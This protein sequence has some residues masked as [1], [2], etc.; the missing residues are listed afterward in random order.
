[1]SE[2]DHSLAVIEA[3]DVAASSDPKF[4][5]L[6]VH[7]DYSMCDGL[8]KV[9]P[10]VA[11]A[12]DL[13]MPALAL[14]DQTN[15]CG[16]VKYYH[17]AHG[18]GIKP[19]IGCDFWVKSDE[20]GDELSRLVILTT[21]NVGY[22]NITELISKAY[23][24]GHIQGKA[25]LDKHWLIEHAH[26]LILL[27]GGREGDV[28]KA[29]LKGNV[30]FVE[31]MLSFYQQYFPNCYYLELI[32]T[33]RSD[34]ENYLHLAVDLASRYDLPLVAT[35]EVMFL[36]PEDFDAHEIRVAIHDGFTLDDKRR[37][38]KYSKEQYLRSEEEM[39]ELFADIPEALENS[40]EIAKRC[41][42]TV[43]LGEYVLPDF[44]TEGLSIEDFLVKVSEEGLQE[45]LEF[46]FDKDA[47]DFAEKRK[48]YDERL[49]IE[50]KVIN[51][52]GFPGY[53]L[54]VM[55]FIQ[56]SKDNNIPVG[57]G[58]GSGAGSLVAYAQ[59]ITDLDPLEYD[60]LFERFLNPERCLL[61]TSPSP[62]D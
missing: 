18:A 51:N 25:V 40:V 8:K 55:E 10:I 11:K 2:T 28:G 14:T 58:R 13:N 30:E 20:L 48:P 46:L 26:G 39:L 57:P 44:P 5:H 4:I 37:P 49:A 61:Y 56:W 59:K 62:R 3:T 38:R 7:S 22:K 53:F 17:A 41:N 52:M 23:L 47:P 54:I 33:G 27:S 6:R 35:N 24:R 45:R 15:L 36:S 50:L 32:R 60:L 9:K 1:M 19:I 21:N 16:L 43:T 29:L 34:E 12:A 42:V 31:Q